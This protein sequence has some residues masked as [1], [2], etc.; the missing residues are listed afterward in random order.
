M[1]TSLTKRCKKSKSSKINLTSFK[2]LY[3]STV[4]NKTITIMKIMKLSSIHTKEIEDMKSQ[5]RKD[6][7]KQGTQWTENGCQ[8]SDLQMHIFLQTIKYKKLQIAFSSKGFTGNM[9]P[10]L[11]LNLNLI[12]DNN[13]KKFTID[14]KQKKTMTSFKMQKTISMKEICNKLSLTWEIKKK[15]TFCSSRIKNKKEEPTNT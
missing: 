12:T 1:M 3:E 9:L 4:P 14:G 13:C 15:I 5:S 10:N 11:N 8:S 7:K 6:S 2:D